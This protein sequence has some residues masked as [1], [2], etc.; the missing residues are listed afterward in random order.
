MRVAKGSHEGGNKMKYYWVITLILFVICASQARGS[1]YA[2]LLPTQGAATCDRI[3][4]F[5][6]TKL[7][8][9]GQ[10]GT[11]RHAIHS[12][13]Q[14]KREHRK[15]SCRHITF[16]I[17]G[18]I[19]LSSP[20]NIRSDFVTID[21]CD[22]PGAGITITQ[23]PQSP[24]GIIIDGTRRHTHDVLIQCLR[25]LGVHNQLKRHK[26]GEAPLSVDGDC[27][28]TSSQCEPEW[29]AN[30][31]SGGVSRIAF[32]RLTY[33][34]ATDKLTFWGKVKNASI[35]RSL[36]YHNPLALLI[37]FYNGPTDLEKTHISIRGNIFTNNNERNP[38]LRGWI[39]QLDIRHNIIHRWDAFPPLPGTD[40][41]PGDGYGIRI[42]NVF[43]E[44]S[45][46]A[47]I[48]ENIFLGDSNTSHRALIYG[49][50]P[51]SDK[52]EGL[53]SS[54]NAQAHASSTTHSAHHATSH[55]NS[56]TT[57]PHTRSA[58]SQ[59]GK[60]YVQGNYLPD[61]NCDQY[62][63]ID[64]P[65]AIGDTSVKV[66]LRELCDSLLLRVGTPSRTPLEDT[67][68][69]AVKNECLAAVIL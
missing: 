18:E 35:T 14:D 3:K 33:G 31:Q 11:L 6:V 1:E 26:V 34:M 38:Q 44:K 39:R 50:Q 27:A 51:G 68:L 56:H 25:F 62:S 13:T 17:Q 20:L 45:V 29:S 10:S 54:C 22:A 19:V 2:N 53:A 60:L 63:T 36:F 46:N 43:G 52:D 28:S 40:G 65:L 37:S 8:D 66:P 4:Q 67:L 69:Q 16:D 23:N 55:A 24:Y 7:T 41:Y 61:E 5:R 42:K 49:T 57:P 59:M 12:A 30:D 64:E 9:T 21:G 47:N 48:V 32:D 58:G 15:K